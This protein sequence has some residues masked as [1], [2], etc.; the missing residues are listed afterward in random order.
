MIFEFGVT[1]NK[2][3]IPES[4]AIRLANSS[5]V[6]A[7][8]FL[9]H[10]LKLYQTQKNDDPTVEIKEMKSKQKLAKHLSID[11]FKP[12]RMKTS[13]FPTTTASSG[14]SHDG[15]NDASTP[16]TSTVIDFLSNQDNDDIDDD[17]ENDDDT[18]TDSETD[19]ESSG[20]RNWND[21]T[22]LL[23]EE[24]RNNI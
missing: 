20:Q 24:D 2:I 16:A 17:E 12:R 15:N 7:E 21:T 11:A 3:V 6:T 1:D 5:E 13:Q 18:E 4:I 19:Y 9:K 22:I 14:E 10:F 8:N 23:D